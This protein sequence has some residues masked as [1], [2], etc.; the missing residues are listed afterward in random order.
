MSRD[1]AAALIELKRD[2]VLEEVNNRATSGI[3]PLGILDELRQGMTAVSERFQEGEYFLSELM[4][5]AD[6]SLPAGPLLIPP[7]IRGPA[8]WRG[9]EPERR[10]SDGRFAKA[11][12]E[13]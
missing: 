7:K 1:L 6:L 5:S 2:E 13:G 3:D 8:P 10:R 9:G 11:A 12:S 4:L